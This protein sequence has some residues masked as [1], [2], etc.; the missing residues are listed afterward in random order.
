[1]REKADL[2]RGRG[3]DE[4]EKQKLGEMI[5][6]EPFLFS[7]RRLSRRR[8]SGVEVSKTKLDEEL[9]FT[10]LERNEGRGTS[11]VRRHGWERGRE[12]LTHFDAPG[13]EFSKKEVK[14]ECADGASGKNGVDESNW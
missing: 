10:K 11:S 14:N 8:T 4:A 6:S 12:D 3:E 1:M 5:G 13:R 2:C 7:W 9:A